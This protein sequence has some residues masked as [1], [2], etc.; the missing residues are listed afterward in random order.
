MHSSM[1]IIL[2]YQIVSQLVNGIRASNTRTLPPGS[3]RQMARLL[4][5]ACHGTESDRS[6]VTGRRRRRGRINEATASRATL[7]TAW[8]RGIECQEH[9]AR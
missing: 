2:V 8:F 3:P 9:A 1:H 6:R 7:L 4:F 5:C